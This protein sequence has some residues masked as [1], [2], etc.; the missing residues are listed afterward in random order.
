MPIEK[1]TIKS[2]LSG[3]VLAEFIV[4]TSPFSVAEAKAAGEL[5]PTKKI[6]LIAGAAGLTTAAATL[7]W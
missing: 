3:D 5:V 2:P 6:L 7:S 1:W 4:E